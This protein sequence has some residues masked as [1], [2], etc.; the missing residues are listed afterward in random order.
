MDN[1]DGLG[2]TLEELSFHSNKTFIIEKEKISKISIVEKISKFYNVDYIDLSL[3]AGADFS[4]VG[5]LSPENSDKINKL[6]K[7]GVSIIGYV[8]KEDNNGLFLKNEDKKT[9]IESKGW[10]YFENEEQ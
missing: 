6:S 5:T 10:N 2:Q 8:D 9:R 1:T 7:K 3:D 4:L